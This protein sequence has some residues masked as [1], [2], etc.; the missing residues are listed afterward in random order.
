MSQT[1]KFL[2]TDVIDDLVE[3]SKS[4]EGPL[5]KLSLFGKKID[6]QELISY[7]KLELEGYEL[8]KDET[9]DYRKTISTL[10]VIIQADIKYTKQIPVSYLDDP[11]D[12]KLRYLEISYGVGTLEQMILDRNKQQKPEPFIMRPIPQ[13]MFHIIKKG[14]EKAYVFNRRWYVEN[15][16]LKGNAY[17]VNEIISVV[18]H[19]LLSFVTSIADNFG[20]EI[21]LS[22][23]KGVNQEKN[24]QTINNYMN[25]VITNTGDGSIINTGNDS[26]VIATITINKEDREY[27]K[28]L[29]VEESRIDDLNKILDES[30]EDKPHRKT[31]VLKWLSEVSAH[32]TAIGLTHNLPAIREFVDKLF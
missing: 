28:G 30:K 4:L 5:M 14:V 29:G 25:T 8:G 31:S 19:R 17:Q 2:I 22:S 23:F 12:K 21:E 26:S 27:L 13:E 24:N 18:R 6:N 7:T 1:D 15:A 9:P 3:P 10:E 11:F 32:A 16:I 20:Y